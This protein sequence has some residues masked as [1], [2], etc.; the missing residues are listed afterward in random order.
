[1]TNSLFTSFYFLGIIAEIIIRIPFRIKTKRNKAI[2]SRRSTLEN[3]SLLMVVISLLLPILYAASTLLNFANY[4]IPIF[5]GASGILIE[6]VAVY[7]FWRS[8]VDLDINFSALVQI[9][10]SHTLITKGV[11]SKIR[12]PMYA[13]TLLFTIA[14]LLLIQNWIAGPAGLVFF[15]IFYLI[16]L[17][18]EEKLMLETFGD[19]YL[20]YSSKTG[21]I[22]P[23]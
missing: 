12:H 8:H 3:V 2:I 7:L 6:I 23:C 15:T 19:E 18:V 10:E 9:R 17:P 20:E 11:Y 4:S 14:Q 5:A 16:R 1:M 21:R 22:F 13:A